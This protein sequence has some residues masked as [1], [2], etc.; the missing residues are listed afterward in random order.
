MPYVALINIKF[1][2]ALN[3]RLVFKHLQLWLSHVAGCFATK[4]V[5]SLAHAA[6]QRSLRRVARGEY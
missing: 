2:A 3:R 1:R 4:K 5:P 6:A